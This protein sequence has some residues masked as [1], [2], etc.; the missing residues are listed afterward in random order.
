VTDPVTRD[1]D[2][3]YHPGSFNDRLLRRLK[4]RM[5]EAQLH[6]LRPCLEGGIR[7]KAGRAGLA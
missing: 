7:N 6:A 2:G 4:R 1:A 5:T 3:L